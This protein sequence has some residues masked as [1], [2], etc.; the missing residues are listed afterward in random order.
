MRKI[1]EISVKIQN[2]KEIEIVINLII[3]TQMIIALNENDGFRRIF[4]LF[5]V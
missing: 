4:R 1:F 2:N 3:Q 5:F